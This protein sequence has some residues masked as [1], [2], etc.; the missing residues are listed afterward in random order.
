MGRHLGPNSL[1]YSLSFAPFL[2][3]RNRDLLVLQLR[4]LDPTRPPKATKHCPDIP[5]LR[6]YGLVP[7]FLH[8]VAVCKKEVQASAADRP[9]DVAVLRSFDLSESWLHFSHI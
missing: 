4:T 3:G 7:L 8:W 2:S 5:L 6:I 1:D 9:F